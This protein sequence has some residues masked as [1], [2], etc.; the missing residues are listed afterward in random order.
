[1]PVLNS[2]DEEVHAPPLLFL[3]TYAPSLLEKGV[4]RVPSLLPTLH[5]SPENAQRP[6]RTSS[7]LTIPPSLCL[8]PR[9]VFLFP[10][11]ACTYIC[12][13]WS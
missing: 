13:G 9:H 5:L 7:R 1:M 11:A 3:N 6:H 8:I 10:I 12:T 2:Y 4:S